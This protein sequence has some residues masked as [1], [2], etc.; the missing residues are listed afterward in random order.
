MESV[1][2]CIKFFHTAWY[3]GGR[4]SRA[5]GGGDGLGREAEHRGEARPLVL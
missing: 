2:D 3:W 4:M 5:C 1:A